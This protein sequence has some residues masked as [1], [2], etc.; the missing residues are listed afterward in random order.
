[1]TLDCT[2]FFINGEW[3]SPPDR[4]RLDVIN[5]ATEQA[6]AEISIANADD[7]DAAVQ[8]ARAAFPVWSQS[9]VDERITVLENILAGMNDRLSELADAIS[10]EMGAPLSLASTAQVRAGMAHFRTIIEILKG[11]NFGLG[12]GQFD[13]K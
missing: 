4:P 12:S 3:V 7:V 5:P 2:Q 8:A 9:S 10:S 13:I 1:M 6:F 11:F